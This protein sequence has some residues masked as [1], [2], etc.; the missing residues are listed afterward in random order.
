MTIVDRI[1]FSDGMMQAFAAASR[2]INP[3]HTDAT[4][5]ARTPFG[6]PVVYGVLG[7]LGALR[8]ILRTLPIRI[9]HLKADFVRPLYVGEAYAV[10][11]TAIGTNGFA[12]QLL[13]GDSVKQRIELTYTSWTPCADEVIDE[14]VPVMRTCPST[15]AASELAGRVVPADYIPDTSG[16]IELVDAL[17]ISRGRLPDVQLSVLLWSSW[18]I[19]MEIPGSQALYARI[20]A[21]FSETPPQGSRLNGEARVSSVDEGSGFVTLATELTCQGVVAAKV[22]LEALCRPLP[23]EYDLDRLVHAAT[24]LQGYGGK[25]VLVTGASRGIGSLLALG[26]GAAGAHVF[27][28]HRY[29]KEQAEAIAE[30]IRAAGGK[31]NLISGDLQDER[32]WST[33]KRQIQRSGRGLD[34]FIHSA[35]T[36]ILPLEL[37][38]LSVERVRKD[39][40]RNVL[41]TITGLQHLLPLVNS[42]QGTVA[43]ISS[44]YLDDPPPGFSW[45]VA[46]KQ[47]LEGLIATAAREHDKNVFVALRLPRLLSD[48]TNVN[49]DPS[50]TADTVDVAIEALRQLAAANSTGFQLV[51]V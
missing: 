33:C 30:R 16:V 28:H 34:R 10:D 40:E 8:N 14:A 7:L 51:H 3:L 18:F 38:E 20:D 2:D 45:Y 36:P 15:W 39:F 43:L 42:A 11:V 47:A 17:G 46:Q 48:Q 9:T 41:S 19:G 12:I 49:I 29:S 26:A 44:V 37:S 23:V 35:F 50:V 24:S 4:Y 21:D 31:A 6:Y 1:T 13:G 32:F 27:V 22:G 25:R 5:A